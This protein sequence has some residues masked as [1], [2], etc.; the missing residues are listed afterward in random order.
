[1]GSRRRQARSS[2]RQGPSLSLTLQR[3]LEWEVHLGGHSRQSLRAAWGFA[4]AARSSAR[5]SASG[6][7]SLFLR[8]PRSSCQKPKHTE[9]GEEHSERQLQG[10]QVKEWKSWGS[11][12]GIRLQH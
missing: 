3:T 6:G 8:D 4:N 10:L 7:Q 11:S 5:S 1:M 2:F 12:P 9:E